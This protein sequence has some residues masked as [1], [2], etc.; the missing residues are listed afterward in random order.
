MLYYGRFLSKN[1]PEVLAVMIILRCSMLNEKL[2]DDVEVE[3]IPFGINF[4]ESCVDNSSMGTDTTSMGDD[5]TGTYNKGTD[6]NDT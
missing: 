1:H 5:D 3:F 2:T 6:D 4:E